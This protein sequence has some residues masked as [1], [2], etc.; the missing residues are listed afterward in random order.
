MCKLRRLRLRT[1]TVG[2]SEA[3]CQQ[4]R[5]NVSEG[6]SQASKSSAVAITL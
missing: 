5:R 2:E 1:G 3:L 4:A 6:S